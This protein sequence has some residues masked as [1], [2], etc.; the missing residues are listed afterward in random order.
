MNFLKNSKR[1]FKKKKQ[2]IEYQLSKEREENIK[3]K[4]GFEEKEKNFR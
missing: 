2:Q 1:F 4:I 3:T